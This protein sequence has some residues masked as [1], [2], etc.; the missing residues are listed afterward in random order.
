[1]LQPRAQGRNSGRQ[2]HTPCALNDW[3]TIDRMRR[4]RPRRKWFSYDHIDR[5]GV[6][7]GSNAQRVAL[8]ILSCLRAGCEVRVVFANDPRAR[9]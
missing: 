1:V 3:H 9:Q 4:M 8:Q 2:P 5:S 6:R 7:H